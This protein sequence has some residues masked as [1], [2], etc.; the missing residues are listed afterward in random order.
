MGAS[1]LGVPSANP[2]NEARAISQLATAVKMIQEALPDLQ[3]G[4]EPH[5]AALNAIKSLSRHAAPSA[6]VPGNQ[7]VQLRQLM[8]GAGRDAALQQ[9]MRS[10][11]AGTAASGMPGGAPPGAAPGAPPGPAA[12]GGSAGAPGL[13]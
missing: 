4:S 11:G 12:P 3:V 13:V 1:P 10:Q 6:E 2:G 8:A 9:L 7:Q 5:T